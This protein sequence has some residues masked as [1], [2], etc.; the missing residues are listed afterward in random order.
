MKRFVLKIPL[1]IKP[2]Y[3]VSS[4]DFPHAGF[5]EYADLS[6]TALVSVSHDFLFGEIWKI[7]NSFSMHG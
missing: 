7:T 1:T 4:F 5:K 6:T 2:V 3:Y